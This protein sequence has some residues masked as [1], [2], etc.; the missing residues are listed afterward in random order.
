ML[1]SFDIPFDTGIQGDFHP[2]LAFLAHHPANFKLF[3][4]MQGGDGNGLIIRCAYTAVDSFVKMA[5][6]D[7][8][9]SL[10]NSIQVTD[11]INICLLFQVPAV[12]PGR[13]SQP[14]LIR[15]GD[16]HGSRCRIGYSSDRLSPD[17][18]PGV[19]L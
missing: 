4:K 14:A 12:E 18:C 9:L 15:H 3:I 5:R 17:I 1:N 13:V 19:L 8:V 6:M 2:G 11:P 7:L 16:I 10:S